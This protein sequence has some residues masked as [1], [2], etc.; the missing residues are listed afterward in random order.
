MRMSLIAFTSACLTFGCRAGSETVKP[1]IELSDL[2]APRATLNAPLDSGDRVAI[3][4]AAHHILPGFGYSL[5]QT[6]IPETQWEFVLGPAIS[7]LGSCPYEVIDNGANEFRSNCR[8]QEGYEWEGTARFDA[9]DGELGAT[10]WS[11]WDLSVT[12][13]TEDAQLGTLL[14]KGQTLDIRPT[15]NE[16]VLHLEAN[17]QIQL[18][19]WWADRNK[20]DLERTYADLRYSGW[21]EKHAPEDS[22]AYWTGQWTIQAGEWGAVHGTFERL[23]LG[24]CESEPDGVFQLDDGSKWLFNGSTACDRCVEVSDGETLETACP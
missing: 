23:S 3:W 20:D 11:T 12:G 4:Q 2:G 8:S 9:F 22:A 16:V 14:I 19:Q 15:E 24:P 13:D 5:P 10:E 18:T 21:M 6:Q 1:V 17:M 7:D